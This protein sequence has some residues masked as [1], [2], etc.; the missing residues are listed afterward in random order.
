MSNKAT[1]TKSG[2]AL[3]LVVGLAV[4]QWGGTVKVEQDGPTLE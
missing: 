1:F 3:F 2:L 4:Q